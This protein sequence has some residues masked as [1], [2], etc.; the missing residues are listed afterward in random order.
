MN[1]GIG[2]ISASGSCPVAVTTGDRKIVFRSNGNIS[3]L[4]LFAKSASNATYTYIDEII[5]LD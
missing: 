3:A 5:K 1:E 4:G 2:Q